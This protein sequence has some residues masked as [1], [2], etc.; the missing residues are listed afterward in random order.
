MTPEQD[1]P[2]FSQASETLADIKEKAGNYAY[3]FETQ[4]QLNHILSSKVDVGRR[5]RQAYQTD[6]KDNLQ[7]IARQE[8]PELRS[9]IEHF[10]ALFSHNG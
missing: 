7:E 1:K 3:L 9:Q 5:I 10:H 6:D 2:H 4:A 8:L